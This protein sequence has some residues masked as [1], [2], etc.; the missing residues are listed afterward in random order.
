MNKPGTNRQI[1]VYLADDHYTIRKGLAGIFSS[2]NIGV[3]G[4][5]GTIQA[6]LDE[7]PRLS[8]DVYVVDLNMD[9]TQGTLVIEQLLAKVPQAR[10][11]VYSMRE[12]P[13]LIEACYQAGAKAFVP[14]TSMPELIIEAIKTV[15]EGETIFLPWVA[16]KLA[17]LTTSRNRKNDPR[18]VLSE[19]ELK[20][21]T[22]LAQGSSTSLTAEKLG[23][24]ARS[25]TYY[26]SR[27]K[28]RLGIQREDFTKFA[29]EYDILQSLKKD[30]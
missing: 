23:I 28:E 22:E 21:F 25:V 5:A 18:V 4:E 20:V 13:S 2:H 14:K 17:E 19:I 26:T 24:N 16:Q 30:E 10:I 6:L 11:L 1:Q 15:S 9:G 8:P 12:T 27:I 7:G 29:I 3:V